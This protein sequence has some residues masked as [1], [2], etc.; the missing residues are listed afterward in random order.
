MNYFYLRYT[1]P[2]LF[3]LRAKSNGYFIQIETN[4]PKVALKAN[5]D[6]SY[7]KTAFEVI[8]YPGS[9]K[10]DDNF[11]VILRSMFNGKLLTVENNLLFANAVSL[12]D[13]EKFYVYYGLNNVI[14]N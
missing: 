8:I 3:S 1:F 10:E 7:E 9:Q 13:K 6:A 14:G 12:S 11:I 4:N 5:S 2:K